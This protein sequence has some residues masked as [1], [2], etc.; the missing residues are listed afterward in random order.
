MVEQTPII[1]CLGLNYK[2]HAKEANMPIPDTP[3]LFIKPRTSLN[4]P[5]PAKINIPKIARDDTADYEAELTFIMSK[6]GKDIPESE[7]LDYVLGY[8]C[9]N[10]V[11]ARTQQLK[12]SQWNFGKGEHVR[13]SPGHSCLQGTTRHGWSSSHWTCACVTKRN[14]RSSQ[15]CDARCAQWKCCT[16]YK[17]Q[18][19]KNINYKSRGCICCSQTDPLALIGK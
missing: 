13:K 17:H 3:V 9:G 18:V 16:D 2:D 10:D 19:R 14:S 11:S 15:A 1:R 8:T 6:D 5:F 4:R 7:A 12:N